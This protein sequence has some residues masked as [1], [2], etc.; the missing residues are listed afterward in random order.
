[1]GK[2]KLKSKGDKHK[3]KIKQHISMDPTN[4]LNSEDGTDKLIVF[5]GLLCFMGL[6]K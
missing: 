5:N 2:V 4:L 1:M 6:I 3:V